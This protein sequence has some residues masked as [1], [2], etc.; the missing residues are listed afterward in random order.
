MPDARKVSRRKI[1]AKG[2]IR[3]DG[4]FSMRPCTIVD[5]SNLGVGISTENPQL[6]KDPFE[7]VTS[8]ETGER[9]RCVVKWRNGPRIGAKFVES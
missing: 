7:L 1:G 5:D 6:V 9:R 4:G 2:W 3:L 8:R